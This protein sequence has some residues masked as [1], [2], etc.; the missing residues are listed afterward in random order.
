VGLQH[1]LDRLLEI[2]AE[3]DG[4][5]I[6]DLTSMALIPENTSGRA[7]VVARQS[8]IAAGIAAVEKVLKN[9]DPTLHWTPLQEDAARLVPGDPLGKIE[10]PVRAMLTAERLVLNLLG[11]LCGVAT[12][13]AMYV[14]AVE[15]TGARV[16]DTRK[17]TLGWRL[18]EKYAVRCGGA[19]NHRTGLFDAVLIKDNHLAHGARRLEGETMPSYTPAEA[20]LRAKAYLMKRE[21]E[22]PGGAATIVEVEVD[23]LDQLQDVLP[24]EPDI[25]LL[26]NMSP[27]ELGEAV[28]LRDRL[29][30]GVELEAS[31]GITLQTIR[32]VAESGVERISCGAL[33]H[34]AIN[35]DI[36]LDWI[37]E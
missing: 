9:I 19:Q 12:L 2:A 8:G 23:S 26:D 33:T 21:A 35:L 32:A 27:G 37:G 34:S 13:T 24:A 6:G 22:L 16:Y 36:G 18:L 11:K 14:E 30:P 3:E 25:V 4:A 17:T 31:G 20:I 28:A 5:S 1:A 29:A 7:M 15:G 10:G